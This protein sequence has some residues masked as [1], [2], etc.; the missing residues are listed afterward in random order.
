MLTLGGVLKPYV[1]PKF[2]PFDNRFAVYPFLTF[3]HIIPGVLFLVLTPLQFSKKLRSHSIKTHRVMGW[4]VAT[5]AFIIGITAL[6]MSFKMAIGG[7][8]E[9]AATVTFA[10]FFL[11][12]LFK[13]LYH[14]KQK[15]ISLHREWMIRMFAIGLAIATVRPIVGLFFGFSKLGPHQFFGIAFWIGFILHAIIAEIYIRKYKYTG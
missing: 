9:T 2:G 12:A 7:A 14:I 10:L 15:Q 3:L 1:N 5:C 11:F 6:I 8:I 13:A 4:I